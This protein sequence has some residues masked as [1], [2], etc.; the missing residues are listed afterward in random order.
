MFNWYTGY[1]QQTFTMLV[2]DGS[3][4]FSLLGHHINLNDKA[5]VRAVAWRHLH[6]LI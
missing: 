1:L 6:S 4:Y 3:W 5:R 2:V